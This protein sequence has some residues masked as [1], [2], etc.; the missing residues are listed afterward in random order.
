MEAKS[1]WFALKSYVYVEFKE[2]NVLLYDTNQGNRIESAQEKVITL[3]KQLYEPS[4]LGVIPVNNEMLS[5]RC[6]RDFMKEVAEKEMGDLMDTACYPNK[7]IRLIP[8]LSLQKD[9]DRHIEYEDKVAFIG[10]DISKYLTEIN[11][12][13][14]NTCHQTCRHCSSYC[15][16]IHCCTM[17][18]PGNELTIEYL[19]KLLEQLRYTPVNTINIYGGDILNYSYW[20]EL[21]RIASLYPKALHYYIDYK[22]Y[23]VNEFLDSQRIDLIVNFPLDGYHFQ[24]VWKQLKN[25]KFRLHFIVEDEQQCSDAEHLIE[26]YGIEK[27]GIHPYY[28]GANI[29]FFQD[30]IYLNA[31]DI[32]DKTLSMREIFRNRK[33]NSNYFGTLYVLPDGTVKANMNTPALGNLAEDTVLDIIYKELIENTAWRITRN[34]HPCDKCIYQYMCPAPSDY[35]RAIGRYNLCHVIND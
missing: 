20:D 12:Y 14:T 9:I 10:R 25:K 8:I 16:Q 27:Y 23:R 24:T 4:N 26:E 13:L 1:Y 33:L 3:V 18:N 11:I 7:P 32:F 34:A 19:E 22:N 17:N 2:E 28:T 31:E 5:D 35:E 6:I 21:Q 30:N 15:N 29:D